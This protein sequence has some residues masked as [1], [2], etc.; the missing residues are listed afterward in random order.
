MTTV[1]I[2]N[3]TCFVYTKRSFT[4]R[5]IQANGWTR[6]EYIDLL[7]VTSKYSSTTGVEFMTQRGRSSGVHGAWT[8]DGQ[9]YTIM[10]NWR[11][12]TGTSK[13]WSFDKI[14]NNM[15]RTNQQ[16]PDIIEI[17]MTH[18]QTIAMTTLASICDEDS[19]VLLDEEDVL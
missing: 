13:T 12:A 1:D 4:Y 14:D 8:Y 5:H 10:F 3:T 15:Y 9:R 16:H 19:W 2:G 18:I 7:T 6:H 11:G 17:S